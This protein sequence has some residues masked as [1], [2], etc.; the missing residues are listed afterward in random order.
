MRLCD[1]NDEVREHQV[2]QDGSSES[3]WKMHVMKKLC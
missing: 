3:S 2:L 1:I